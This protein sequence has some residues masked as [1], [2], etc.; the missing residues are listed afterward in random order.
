MKLNRLKNN[1][2]ILNRLNKVN[3]KTIKVKHG[4]VK[5]NCFIIDKKL[6]YIS[7][8]NEIYNKDY[9][10]FKNLE[11]L[12]IDCLRYNFHPSHFNLESVLNLINL[13][14]PKKSILTNLHT[15][16]DYNVLKNR[17]PKNVVPAYDG[18]SINF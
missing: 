9:K 12:I 18:L 2:L 5:S 11:Y 3:L 16:L 6:A 10:Y 15:D 8:V 13:F 14:K 1:H 7:D 4:N 17:L